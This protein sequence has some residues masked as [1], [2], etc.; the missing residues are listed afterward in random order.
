MNATATMDMGRAAV[1][2]D[3][4]SKSAMTFMALPRELRDVIYED[5]V[6]TKYRFDTCQIVNGVPHFSEPPKL[7]E[8]ESDSVKIIRYDTRIAGH[9]SVTLGELRHRSRGAL[10][11][12]PFPP[13]PSLSLLQTSTRVR[14]EAL[15]VIYRKGT[16]LFVLNHPSHAPLSTPQSHILIEHFNNV[17][18]FL[19]LASIH[20]HS[21][22]HTYDFR[23][24]NLTMQLIQRIADCTSMGGTCT[25]S[26]YH[27]LDSNKLRIYLFDHLICTA[28]ELR[29]FK[30]VVLRFG[31]SLRIT[32]EKLSTKL[33]AE[34]YYSS[35]AAHCM[36]FDF[37]LEEN[38]RCLGPCEQSYDYE[39]FFCMTFYPR[40]QLGG[41]GSSN[42]EGT[43][44]SHYW[45]E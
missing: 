22:Y 6:G 18:I 21:F 42:S 20:N 7:S 37:L 8:P 10:Y 40:E 36:Y 19:D 32:G 31:N 5:L 25:L 26:T 34:R 28:A 39:G 24:T 4:P 16:L 30:K 27:G 38:V 23:A 12:Y 17:E 3:E 29:V 2:I 9:R 45:R 13:P 11:N 43:E 35:S 33:K 14:D 41:S 15:D 1:D 44:L